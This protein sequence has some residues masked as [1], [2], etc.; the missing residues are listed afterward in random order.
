MCVTR[1]RRA[2]VHIMT[3]SKTNG[4]AALVGDGMLPEVQQSGVGAS[5][6]SHYV[7][8]DLTKRQRALLVV[9]V[10]VTAL[11]VTYLTG[12]RPGK[13]KVFFLLVGCCCLHF[14]LTPR[15]LP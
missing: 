6:E 14:C 15:F 12:I 9:S 8:H 2:A 5:A 4:L 3:L 1:Q 11:L 13:G 7:E 10:F